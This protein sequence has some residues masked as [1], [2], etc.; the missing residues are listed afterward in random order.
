[1]KSLHPI[2]TPGRRHSVI[3][4][5]LRD[6]DIAY[7]PDAFD[8]PRIKGKPQLQSPVRH[9]G[10]G[11]W[12]RKLPAWGFYARRVRDL[13]LNRVQVKTNDAQDRRPVVLAD[14][15]G[16]F[17]LD[18]LAHSPVLPDVRVIRC[19]GV[20]TFEQDDSAEAPLPP[21]SVA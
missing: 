4:V 7:T 15:V 2:A 13:H 9:P 14:D 3:R 10:V 8:D 16:V 11:V 19:I 12:N 20:G 5:G 18:H 1:M 21:H 17:R 6:I